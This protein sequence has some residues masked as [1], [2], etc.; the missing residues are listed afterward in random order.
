MVYNLHVLR[1][2]YMILMTKLVHKLGTV[3]LLSFFVVSPHKR[4][5]Q[6]AV[7]W[8]VEVLLLLLLL[9]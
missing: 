9:L 1:T 3:T 5:L 2:V 4:Y 7:C 6:T 8:H